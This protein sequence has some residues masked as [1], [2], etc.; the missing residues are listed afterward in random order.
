M[1]A[2]QPDEARELY[3]KRLN[4]V[5]YY[6]LGAYQTCMEL[7]RALFLDGEE[8]PPQLQDQDAQAWTLNSLANSY[9]LSGQ[10]ARA[11][12]MFERQTAIRQKQDD[13]INLATGLLNLADDELRLG[14]LAAGESDLRKSIDLKRVANDENGEAV[15]R[16]GVSR[17]LAYEGQ[18]GES[19]ERLTRASR[20]FDAMGAKNTNFVSV[21]RSDQ[22]LAAL[23]AGDAKGALE[24]ARLARR[25]ANQVAEEFFPVERDYVMAEWLIGAALVA[26]AQEGSQQRNHR[27]T[28]AD[29]HLTEALT[30]CRRINLVELEPDILLARA[31]WHQANENTDEALEYA[32]EA[33]A[34]ADRCE[35]RLN[36]A[37]VHNFLAALAVEKDHDA[38]V[39]HARKAFDYAVCDGTPHV[40]KPALDEAIRLLEEHLVRAT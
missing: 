27:L 15:A 37:D 24:A 32:G 2:G 14:A 39:E 22:A 20:V 35:Y 33:L 31:K 38:A 23:L 30:R 18:F 12:L 26:L 21:I 16:L 40:Y 6:R 8:R 25:L 4:E 29:T 19:D 34:I 13:K 1:G 5:L 36:Q 9:S 28:E 10:P 17:V 11:V 7:L 3:E